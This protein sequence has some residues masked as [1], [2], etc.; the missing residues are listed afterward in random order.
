[1]FMRMVDFLSTQNQ[2]TVNPESLG[3]V[4]NTLKETIF[5]MCSKSCQYHKFHLIFYHNICFL[6]HRNLEF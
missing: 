1:M 5:E 4:N 3:Y 6:G 2:R